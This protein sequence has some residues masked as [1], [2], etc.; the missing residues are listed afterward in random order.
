VRQCI[1][2]EPERAPG[3]SVAVCALRDSEASWRG[4]LR[5]RAATLAASLVLG[6]VAAALLGRRLS[7]PL[8]ALTD[9]AVAVADQAATGPPVPASRVAEFEAPARR[10][11]RRRGDCCAARAPPSISPCSRPAPC[12]AC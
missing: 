5:E 4:A 12:S 1:I 11:A 2:A 6:L 7:R 9:H 10:R 8:A 3:W